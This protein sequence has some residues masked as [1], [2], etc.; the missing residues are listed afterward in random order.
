VQFF[1]RNR[2]LCLKINS[3]EW[4]PAFAGTTMEFEAAIRTDPSSA[5]HR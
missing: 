3:A 1:G 4:V 5:S 2:P